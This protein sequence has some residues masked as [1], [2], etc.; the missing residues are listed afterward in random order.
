M[1]VRRMTYYAPAELGQAV[2]AKVAAVRASGERIDYLT[3]VPDGEPSLDTSLEAHIREVRPLGIPIAV[4]T[5]ASLMWREDVRRALAL[6]DWVSVKVDAAN[7]PLWRRLDR[8]HG[9]LRLEDI[10]NGA[11]AFARSFQGTL[12]TET[13][14]VDGVN[15]GEAILQEIAAFVIKL[16]PSRS[17]FSVPSRPPAEPWVRPPS[18]QVLASAV[19]LFRASGQ[20]CEGL[21][22]YEGN[23]FVL[24]GEVVDDLMSICAVHPMR[25]DAV[26][27]FVK[28][29]GMDWRIVDNL[30][31]TGKM[32]VQTHQG[33]RFYRT[34]H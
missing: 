22:E 27:E 29:A 15:T 13:M 8:P 19:R 17:Y 3:F 31:K 28:N 33:Q 30:V 18:D 23:H 6:A 25:E 34:S 10:L 26:R 4:I 32:L 24:T 12:V 11:L 21:G 2:K 5:N 1:R 16:A 9:A 20:P 14:L 7:E